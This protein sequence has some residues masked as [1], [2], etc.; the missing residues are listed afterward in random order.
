MNKDE[1]RKDLIKKRKSILN[2]NELSKDIINQIINLDIYKRAKVIAIYN[3][4][5]MEVDTSLLIKESLKNKIVLLPRIIDNEMVFFVINKDTKYIKSN[6]DILEP[7]GKKHLGN[8]DLIIVPGVAFDDNL[9]RL[10]FGMGYYDKYLENKNIYKM[11]ICF[12]EQ[13]VKELP[14]LKHDIKMDMIISEK[15][16]IKKV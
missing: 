1:L 4:M 14:V 8:I 3:S 2:K 13:I 9:N 11:G 15:R 12:D 16:I 10:G 7:I 5:K 6:F